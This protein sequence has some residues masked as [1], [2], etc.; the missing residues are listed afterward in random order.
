M[1]LKDTVVD[2]TDRADEEKG[3][4]HPNIYQ[5]GVE[6]IFSFIQLISLIMVSKAF[7]SDLNCN[8]L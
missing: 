2:H 1:S 5:A 6:V 8:Q 7:E 3:T 4:G